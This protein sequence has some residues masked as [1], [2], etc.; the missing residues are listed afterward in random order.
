[1]TRIVLLGVLLAIVTVSV[2]VAADPLTQQVAALKKQIRQKNA[3]ID[4]QASQIQAQ[5]ALIEDQQATITRLQNRIANQP[6]PMEAIL[7]RDTDGLWSAMT[8]IW[9]AFPTLPDD[10]V[11]GYD[12]TSNTSGPDTDGVTLTSFSFYRWSGC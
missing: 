3:R 6:T 11:C 2:S 5:D 9:R 8:A 10:Q 4:D 7:S 1:M 12:S